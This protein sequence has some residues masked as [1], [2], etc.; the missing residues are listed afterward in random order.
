MEANALLDARIRQ[1]FPVDPGYC[2]RAPVAAGA[3]RR[4]QE[5]VVRVLFMLLHQHIHGLLGQRY[6][7]DGVLGFRLRHHQF[8]VDPSDLL[9]Y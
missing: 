2:V 7:A 8:P 5:G 3:G 4:E 9:A 1:Q 6:L